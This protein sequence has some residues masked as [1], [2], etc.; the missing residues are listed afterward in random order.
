MKE[1]RYFLI[2]VVVLGIAGI[3]GAVGPMTLTG[4]GDL[5]RVATH[6]NQVVVTARY[7]DGTVSELVVPQ[8]ANAVAD[9]LQVGVDEATGAL[10]VLWQKK[11]GM[12]A[13]LRLAGY[14]DGTWIGPMTFAGNDGT[15]AYNPVML[16]NRPVSVI[17]EE[18]EEGE[19]PVVTEL[20]TSFLHLAW[21]SQ[22]S[23]TDPGF[24]K[25]AAV[26]LQSNGVPYFR[27][28]EPV[29]LFD[30]LPYGVGCFEFEVSDNLRHPKLFI[31]P[32]SGN[33][34]V[35]A[36]DLPS[37]HFQILELSPE[38]VEDDSGTAKRRRQ[39]IILRHGATIALR[40]ALPLATGR[41]EVG[42]GLKLIMHWNGE[43][44]DALHYL[45]LDEEGISETKS[46]LLDEMLNHEQAVDLIRG[47][48][49]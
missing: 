25:Y 27:G 46:L 23:E 39:I 14:L 16:I 22:I 28:M 32:Q 15:A 40:P 2:A 41:L 18:T 12:E 33:P 49:N 4:A 7:A 11:S 42:G 29:E 20:A 24:A 26:E 47:L 43:E 37:C 21:W 38:V 1:V 19:D 31:D 17:E 30:L 3:A 13:R 45:N 36:T 5:Y 6:D 9:S 35:F 8:S 48:T 10:Y 44:G 34:H